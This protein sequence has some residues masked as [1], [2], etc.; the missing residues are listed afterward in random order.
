MLLTNLMFF[1]ATPALALHKMN[2]TTAGQPV[3]LV[4]L[5]QTLLDWQ[6]GQRPHPPERE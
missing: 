2:L 5:W 6:T 4:W 1:Y 3:P